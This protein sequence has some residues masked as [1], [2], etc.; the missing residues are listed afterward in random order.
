MENARQLY[1]FGPYLLDPGERLLLREGEPVSLTPKCFD[2]L[3]V[4]VENSGHL[5]TKEELSTTLAGAIC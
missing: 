1:E 2:L 5:L 3:V 4:L